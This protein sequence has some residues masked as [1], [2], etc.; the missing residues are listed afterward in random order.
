MTT[1]GVGGAVRRR[2]AGAAVVGVVLALAVVGTALAAQ[3]PYRPQQWNLDRLGAGDAW[4][5]AR[6]EGQVVAIVDSGVDL[7]HPDLEDRF[8]RTADGAVLGRD[9][10]DDD[11]V[12][13]DPLGHGTM[14]AGIA[15]ATFDNGIGIAGV[16]PAAQL[17]PVRVLDEEGRGTSSDVEEGIRW[18]VDNGATVVNLSL[19]SATAGDGDSLLGSA[20]VAAPVDAVE[21][22]WDRGV[23]V[24]AAAGNGG[25]GFTDY[26]GSSPVVLVGAT[27]RDDER[28][29]FSDSGRDDLLMAPGVDIV[30]TW[31]RERGDDQCGEDVHAYGI[32]DGTSFA[33]PHVAGGLAV[34]RSAGLDHE[35][36]VDRLRSTARDLG[37]EGR[38]DETGFGRIDLAAAVDGVRSAGGSPEP[39]TPGSPSPSATGGTTAPPSPSPSPRPTGTGAPTTTAP[40]TPAPSEAP[41]TTGPT[42]PTGTTT[43]P[44][45]P[46]PSATPE[47]E[48]TTPDADASPVGA[49]APPP[50]SG[51]GAWAALAVVLLI[52][53]AGAVGRV[54]LGL[55]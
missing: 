43:P 48:V 25:S 30:S 8:V 37:P 14:V 54:Q 34:L 50:T 31:C 47:V 52:G 44:G 15:V 9:V 38:D 49:P 33:A 3:D 36:A 11:A 51:R 26:P 7:E 18:A 39:T 12:P 21:Y 27:D 55:R 45:T 23:I 13:Q 4:E 22:A 17:L 1:R 10:V 40:S 20:T 42:E 6:G 46:P 28:T 32:A 29:D 41:T 5:V 24:V 2:R 19:E 16:A 53:T 35:Q